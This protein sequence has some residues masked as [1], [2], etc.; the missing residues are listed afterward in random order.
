MDNSDKIGKIF[1]MILPKSALT[2]SANFFKKYALGLLLIFAIY[3]ISS[4]LRNYREFFASDI[5]VQVLKKV[6]TV[7]VCS[8]RMGPL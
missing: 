2:N 3:V 8:L 1:S 7:N 6:R 5:Y 4:A